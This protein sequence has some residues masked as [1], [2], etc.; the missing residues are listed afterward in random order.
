MHRVKLLEMIWQD[1]LFALRTMR[2]QPVFAATAVLTLAFAIGGNTAAFAVIRA[3]LLKPLPYPD[4]DRLMS[5]SGGATPAR[6]AE[7]KASARSFTGIGAFTGGE[8]PA[9][10]GGAEPEVVKGVRVSANFLQILGVDPLLGRGFRAEEDLPG[11]TPVVMISA[12]LWQRRFAGDPGVL[13]KTAALAGTPYTIIGVL[14]PRFSFPF[15]DLDVWM[16]APSEWPLMPPKSR[17]LSPFL[18]YSPASS[19]A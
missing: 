3:V 12:A 6:Y 14:P 19:Q 4:S 10:S 5:I 7:M 15:P 1:T 16:T 17:A 18:T 9:L 13:G 2:K 8:S 11:G